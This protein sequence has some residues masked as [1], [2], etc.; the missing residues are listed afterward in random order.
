MQ[1]FYWFQNQDIVQNYCPYIV[2]QFRKKSH[3]L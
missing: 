3:Q 2:I 1:K